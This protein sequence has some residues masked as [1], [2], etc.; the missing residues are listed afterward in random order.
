MT[1]ME[2]IMGVPMGTATDTTMITNTFMTVIT[3][4]TTSLR[5]KSLSANKNQEGILN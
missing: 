5:R 3:T 2:D 1:R 4:I